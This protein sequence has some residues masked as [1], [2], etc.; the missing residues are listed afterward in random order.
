MEW[1]GRESSAEADLQDS[2]VGIVFVVWCVRRGRVSGACSCTHLRTVG[3]LTR[4][5]HCA[6][7][8]YHGNQRCAAAGE[9]IDR[10]SVTRFDVTTLPANCDQPRL[11]TA[12]GRCDNAPSRNASC[13]PRPRRLPA[14]FLPCH[15]GERSSRV[16][17][18]VPPLHTCHRRPHSPRL[19]L[20]PSTVPALILC[21]GASKLGFSSPE[22]SEPCSPIAA[23]TRPKAAWTDCADSERGLGIA[24]ERPCLFRHT[25]SC[26]H[27][28][29]PA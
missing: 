4:A 5:C 7:G 3:T 22:Q 28:T 9:S 6:H 14:S 23:A 11:P 24:L 27:D 1:R 16:P 19:L 29:I 21:I 10:I 20:A 17:T 26:I 8:S 18:R 13:L 25:F 12:A 2:G 15:A